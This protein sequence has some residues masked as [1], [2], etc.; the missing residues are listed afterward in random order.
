MIVDKYAIMHGAVNF[1]DVRLMPRGDDVVRV[2]C[3]KRMFMH[4]ID[5]HLDPAHNVDQYKYPTLGITYLK[6]EKEL[7][8]E[9]FRISDGGPAIKAAP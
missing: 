5:Y 1:V 6:R 4:T 9:L 2:E 8:T 3:V 7:V